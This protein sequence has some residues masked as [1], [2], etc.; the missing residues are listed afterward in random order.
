MVFHQ[1]LCDCKYPVVSDILLNILAKLCKTLAWM[2]SILPLIF[3]VPA[4]QLQITFEFYS[5]IN[6]CIFRLIF[7]YD[8]C[9]FN[10]YQVLLLYYYLTIN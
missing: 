8:N 7:N 3:V 9:R 6:W 1:S 4:H 5:F 10:Q 2:A